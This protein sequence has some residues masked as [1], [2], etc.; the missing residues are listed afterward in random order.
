MSE[1]FKHALVTGN[2]SGLGKGLTEVLVQQNYQVLG[3]SRRGCCD[4]S[5]NIRD[6]YCDLSDL[7]GIP[8]AFDSLLEGIKEL[9]VVFLN[10]GVLGEIKDISATRIEEIKSIMDIN[11]WSNKVI[12]DYLLASSIQIKQIVLI[13][14]G[15][16]VMGNRGWGAYALSKAS[17]NMLTRLYSH[18]FPDTHLT[19]LA[20]GLVE[21]SMMDY[22]CTQVD[23]ERFTAVKRIQQ[24]RSNQTIQSARQVAEQILHVLPEL[25]QY[26]SGSF[27][28]IRQILA[29]EEYQELL[30]ARNQCTV[31]AKF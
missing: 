23:S 16:A 3:C 26:E 30:K 13:S 9:D 28:D 7:D 2:S 15:A 20:P 19:A 6:I 27:I 11:V 25:L 18:E 31:T 21:T 5:G 22:L 1:L 14:S 10:A 8:D 17:L 4:I 24:R 12:L 29:P